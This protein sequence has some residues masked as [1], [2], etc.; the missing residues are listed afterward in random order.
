MPVKTRDVAD[1]GV[2]VAVAVAVTLLLLIV[3][4]TV[5]LPTLTAVR[6]AV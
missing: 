3:A 6:V 2:I 4:D 5:M 1:P